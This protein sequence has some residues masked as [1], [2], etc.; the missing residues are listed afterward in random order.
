[1]SPMQTNFFESFSPFHP[2]KPSHLSNG[3]RRWAPSVSARCK[4]PSEASNKPCVTIDGWA[5]PKTGPKGLIENAY[6]AKDG[7]EVARNARA[8]IE[9]RLGR[10]VISSDKAIDHITP[11]DELP[12]PKEPQNKD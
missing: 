9:H 11:Q 8:D 6:V 3:W 1:M 12:L 4:I 5:T 7:A 10:S 2:R